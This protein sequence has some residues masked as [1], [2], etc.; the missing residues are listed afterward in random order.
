MKKLLFIGGILGI[1]FSFF[2]FFKK[3]LNLALNL[4]Y[5]LK[6][7]RIVELTSSIAKIKTDILI[8]NKSS[9]KLTINSYD[10]Q[11]VYK[12]IPIAKTRSDIPITVGSD[13]SFV[14]EAEGVVDLFKTKKLILPFLADVVKKKPI[15]LTLNGFVDINFLNLNY[16]INLDGKEVTYS[17]NLLSEIGLENRF[18]KIKNK[19]DNLLEN[20]GLKI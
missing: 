18:D 10:I 19:I 1:G 13:N 3:Q 6:N 8:E 15:N 12:E 7:I 16:I 20:V 9:F 17:A 11:F 4:D 5:S 14:I 2:Y